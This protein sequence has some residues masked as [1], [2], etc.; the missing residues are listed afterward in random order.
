M[1][2]RNRAKEVGLTKERLEELYRE[3]TDAEIGVLLGM[4][5]VAVSYFRRKYGIPSI[6]LRQRRD[7]KRPG[8]PVLDD[9]TPAKLADLYSSL[10]QREIGA[11]YGVSKPTISVKLKEF[12]I[13]ALT[14]SDRSTSH[15]EVTEEQKEAFIGV[16]LGDGHL[17][18]RGVFKVSHYQEQIDYLRHLH[19][20]LSPHALPI[21][22]AE[23]EMKNGR[24]TFGFGFQTIQ[25]EWLRKMRSIFYPEGVRIFPESILKELTPR[26]LAYWY[27]D[28]GHLGDGLPTI[29][30]GN[31]DEKELRSV[32]S[33]VGNRFNLDVYSKCPVCLTCQRLGIRARSA[34]AF[35]KMIREHAPPDMLYKFPAKYWRGAIARQPVRTN[36]SLVPSGLVAEVKQ[37]PTLDDSGKEVLVEA[38]F[39]FWSETGFPYHV[40]RPE[41]LTVLLNLDPSHVIQD[42]AIKAR[43]AGQGICQGIMKHIWSASSFRAPSPREL[44]S[45]PLQL[46]ELIRFIL[47]SGDVPNPARMRAALRLWKRSGVYNF[48]PSAAKALVDRF[49]CTGGTVLDPC[50]GYGGRLLGTLLSNSQA[51]YVGYDPSTETHAGLLRLNDW[52]RQYLPD[53]KGTV[54]IRCEM[55]E[56]A[57]FPEN[58][59]MVLTSPPYWCREEY[60]TYEDWLN[61]FWRKVLEKSVLALKS[62]GWLV[63]NVDDFRLW[64]RDYPLVEDTLRLVAEL[65]LGRAEKLLYYLPSPGTESRS[66]SVL[67][68]VKGVCYSLPNT[69]YGGSQRISSCSSCGKVAPFKS[70]TSGLCKG[71]LTPKGS[72]RVCKGCGIEF[73]SA[74]ESANFHSAACYAR[75][76]RRVLREKHPVSG[77]RKFTCF[78]C[79]SQWETEKL[80]NFKYCPSCREAK[81]LEGRVKKCGYR[82]CGVDFT[83]T[84]PKNSMTYCCPEH[85]R[86]E[87]LLRSGLAKDE[88]YFR[89]RSQT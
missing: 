84:S 74:T 1:A 72:F 47:K 42:G 40:P 87:K 25:H 43:Q 66:E 29:A 3:H 5:D 82:Y 55:S 69:S 8:Q 9:L 23:K 58:V 71:C 50:A 16:L 59:D 41:E 77:V 19:K 4:S 27:F 81:D 61:L 33:I 34:D 62:G 85:R 17:L 79:G 14:K 68:W 2:R 12:G 51:N 11:L 45:D 7:A 10:G 24:L 73:K 31:V 86:R 32:L 22:Y 36:E 52:V 76:R 6:S 57:T 63:V 88:S 53:L 46:R 38:F 28:D 18:E 54:D 80:G 89:K 75:Y 35:F 83:D 37:W 15:E 30:L 49:C 64:D 21:R 26:S 67:C 13:P 44:F 48:R 70:L 39:K 60:C 20:L 65:G 56:E 78:L